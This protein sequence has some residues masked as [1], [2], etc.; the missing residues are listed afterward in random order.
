MN[1]QFSPA[2]YNALKTGTKQVLADLGG[3]DAAVT[4][5]RVQRSQLYDYGNV[6]V[7]KFTPIDVVLDLERV[8]GTPHITAALARAQGYMLMPIEIARDR[9]ELS[10]L[11]A[12]IG[13]DFGELF[14]TAATALS[15]DKLTEQER[16]DLVRELDNLRR[17][18]GEAIAFLSRQVA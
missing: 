15:H 14:A 12:E 17:V 4:C 18:T 11:M 7:D 3:A 9:S 16:L 6:A 13:R 2:A 8:G 5:T 1:R 10:A